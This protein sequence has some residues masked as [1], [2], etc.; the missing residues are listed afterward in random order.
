MLAHGGT[1]AESL[2]APVSGTSV[3]PIT[4]QGANAETVNVTSGVF[5]QNVSYITVTGFAFSNSTSRFLLRVLNSTGNKTNS[6]VQGIKFNNNTFTNIGTNG[7]PS[8]TV[9]FVIYLQGIGRDGNY[10][11]ATVNEVGNNT[12][13]GC[14]GRDV[15]LDGSSDTWVHD[16]TASGQH[17]SQ[18]ATNYFVADF[19]ESNSDT[20][21]SI[22]DVA[23][24]NL[25]EKN[26]ISNVTRDAY[27]TGGQV[28]ESN[29]FRGDSTSWQT[30]IRNNTVHDLDFVAW[31]YYDRSFGIFFEANC[32][33]NLFRENIIYNT[34]E[35]G[36]QLGSTSQN[37]AQSNQVINNAIYNIKSSCI[38]L[39]N[40][41]N[42]VVQNNSVS[43][44]GLAQI[45]VSSQSVAYGAMTFNNND[46]FKTGSSL[47]ANWNYD[48]TVT[49]P[50]PS[51]TQTL[52]QFNTS[53]GQTGGLNV[54]PLYVNPG[55]DFH[56]QSNSTLRGAGF[57]T[58]ACDVGAYPNPTVVVAATYY[59]RK[60]GNDSH[61]CTQSSTSNDDAHAMLTVQAGINCTS[62]PDDAVEVNVGNYQENV[63]CSVSG[64]LGHPWIL[65]A[66]AG[67][68]VDISSASNTGY[69]IQCTN[70]SY[71][72]INGL[73]FTHQTGGFGSIRFLNNTS[74]TTAPMVGI[75]VTNN[76]WNGVGENGVANGGIT[77]KQILIQGAGNDASY[78]G[79]AV[80]TISG[81]S[82]TGCYGVFHELDGTSDTTVTNETD[83][84]RHS[85]KNQFTNSYQS[86]FSEIADQTIGANTD[87]SQRNT[88]SSSTISSYARDG[89]V[90]GLLEAACFREF[91]STGGSVYRSNVCHD[92]DYVAWNAND[93]SFGFYFDL[94]G[95]TGDLLTRNIV[96]HVNEA[97]V[98][99]GQTGAGQSVV[100]SVQVVNNTIDQVLSAGIVLGNAKNTLVQNNIVTACGNGQIYVSAVTAAASPL[101][102]F[103]NNDFWKS[104]TN[105]V[106]TWGWDSTVAPFPEPTATQT[107]AQFNTSS[108]QTGAINS[109]PKY[110][111]PPSDY[112]LQGGSPAIN[113]GIGGV[114][115]GAFLTGSSG[116]GGGVVCGP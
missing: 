9:S 49:Y 62:L 31:S 76:S 92:L 38:A 18:I 114:N 29:G 67:D 69:A 73:T 86:F 25:L 71:V 4:I 3:A 44:C 74:K 91:A 33:N 59:V 66:H 43:E 63:T 68:A 84:T 104:G 10:T 48:A 108:G 105:L 110:N 5:F 83:T 87:L 55:T 88:I 8:S 65:R 89:Y 36:I 19:F 72:T 77:F 54:N 113:T 102:T 61:T 7:T 27:I 53:S 22:F 98:L 103:Q 2:S 99:V 75:S 109:D 24:R 34:S 107:L 37:H 106:G 40:A 15:V 51:A 14:Y 42:T 80:N 93:R 41:S 45:S 115:M 79:P 32:N 111:A 47:V 100:G 21:N 94:G 26:T 50:A 28:L 64:S 12:F 85:S 81:N 17:G 58:P 16:N 13:T 101:P 112:T 11:G 116:G 57:C 35:A 46:L 6:P 1:Y 82:C 78:N 90:S 60:G 70:T 96:Y 20:I 95:A 39:I 56:L 30:T 97:G 52:T 23:Q